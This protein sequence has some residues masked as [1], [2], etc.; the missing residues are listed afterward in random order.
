VVGAVFDFRNDLLQG[1]GKLSIVNVNGNSEPERMTA[2]VEAVSGKHED[3]K[4][5]KDAKKGRGRPL[6]DAAA[7]SAIADEI[8]KLRHTSPV[9]EAAKPEVK[10]PEHA[11]IAGER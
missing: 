1:A 6:T 7:A 10:A 8:A 3:G 9:P 5:G 4:E 2:F 11:V